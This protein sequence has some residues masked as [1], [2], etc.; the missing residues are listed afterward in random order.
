MTRWV[1]NDVSA[2]SCAFGEKPLASNRQRN[3]LKYQLFLCAADEI[4]IV[5]FLLLLLD[6]K[7][8][9]GHHTA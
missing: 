3:T 5:D 8:Q 9:E 6:Y 4:E 1:V 7:S 2:L